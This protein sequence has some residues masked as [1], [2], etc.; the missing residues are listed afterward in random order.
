MSA[1]G[2]G[3]GRGDRSG[4]KAAIALL[5]LHEDVAAAVLARLGP[6]E[7]RKLRQET[8]ALGEIS[9]EQSAAVLEELAE[10]MASPLAMARLAG[11]AYLL[12]LAQR[13]FGEELAGEL[14]AEPPPPEPEARDRLRGARVVDLAQ[15]LGYEH[16][17]VA[18]MLLTQLPSPLAAKVLAAMPA[19]QAADIVA[20]LA[21]VEEVPA[22]A[23]AVASQAL[24]RALEAAGGLADA[25][26]RSSFDGLAFSAAVVRELG[27]G[28]NAVLDQL[29]ARDRR[30]A[31]RVRAAVLAL[32]DCAEPA[33]ARA[34]QRGAS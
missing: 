20:R 8:A 17:Q 30:A 15:L 27:G 9:D 5:S 18:A 31:T 34:A 19:E 22:H 24:V 6:A 26:A 11:P 3:S 32:E 25:E 7:L 16:A 12:R 14:L 21:E 28:S 13:A 33:V 2:P 10:R 1:S 4:R 23:V 29:S